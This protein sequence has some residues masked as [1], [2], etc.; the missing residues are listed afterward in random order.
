VSANDLSLGKNAGL[1]LYQ[2]WRTWRDR[3]SH[4]QLQSLSTSAF[5]FKNPASH[6]TLGSSS[7]SLHPDKIHPT[8]TLNRLLVVKAQASER[9][10]KQLGESFEQ[11]LLL[12][13]GYAARIY[14]KLWQGLETDQPVSILMDLPG[15]CEFCKTPPVLECR[16]QG[17]Y[18][19]LVDPKGHQRAKGSGPKGKPSAR[20]DKAKSYFG[21]D[22]L[23][24]YQYDLSIGSE[25]VTESEWLELVNANPLG[26]V[27]GTVDAPEPG[28]N[29]ANAGVL[30]K[31]QKEN[32][33]LTLL[34]FMRLTAEGNEELSSLTAIKLAE[35]LTNST[36][37]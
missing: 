15:A 6:K 9:T 1:E 8:S 19:G 37:K 21:Y 36:T 18:S 17:H 12:N 10:T 26:S 24:Q 20:E 3:I 28:Q 25:Q 2:Q 35:M 16:I 22:T 29:A 27:P 5:S 34:D 31:Q 14:P 32:P 11:N 30:E 4:T 23:V 7:F 33:E 13:L